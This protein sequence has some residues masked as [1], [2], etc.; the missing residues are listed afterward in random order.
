MTALVHT[1]DGGKPPQMQID[2]MAIHGPALVEM[3]YPILP[4][5]P[6]AKC[7]GRWRQS[8]GWEAYPDWTRHCD[9]LTKPFELGIWEKWPGCGIG[10]AGGKLGGFDI[11]ILDADLS[12]QIE[13]MAHTDLGDSPAIRIGRAPKKLLVYRMERPFQKIAMHPLEFIGHGAQF[14]LY[15]IHP[16][17]QEPY[18]WPIEELSEILPH[19]I[20]IVT[21]AQVRGFMERAIKIVP[22][23]MRQNR[24]PPDRSAERYLV[25]GGD[26]RGT[27]EA[28]AEALEHIPNL[29]W[30]YDDWV[31]IGIA[32][33]GSVGPQGADLF[34]AFSAKSKKDRPDY[35]AK[36]WRGLPEP[37]SKGFGTLWELATSYGWC[38]SNDLIFNQ[39]K[40]DARS[41]GAGHELFATLTT[42]AAPPPHD[43]ETGEIIEAPAKETDPGIDAIIADAGGLLGDLVQWMTSTARYPQ[44]LLSLGAALVMCGSLMGHRYRLLNGPD[45]RSNVM[46][47]GLAGSGSGKDH[48]RRCVVKA[49]S[50]AGLEKFY[51]GRSIASAQGLIATLANFHSG[52]MLLDEAGLFFANMMD[53]RAP[54][55]LRAIGSLLMELSTSASTIFYDAA[56]SADRDPD[57]IRY[58]IPDPCFNLFAT[59]VPEPF[60]QALNSGSA[61]G[62]FLARFLMFETPVNYPDPQFDVPPVEEG[63]ETLSPRM[64]Q[65]VA[66][67]NI[68]ATDLAVSARLGALQPRWDGEKKVRRI[69]LPDVPVVPMSADALAVDRRMAIDEVAQKRANEGKTQATSIIA[70]TTE[71]TRRLAL[72]RAVSRDPLTPVVRAEDMHWGASVVALSMRLMIPAVEHNIADT[73]WEANLK[74]LLGIIRKHGGWMDISTLC[75]RCYFL[76]A[77]ERNEAIIQLLEGGKLESRNEPTATKPRT[78]V[79][80]SG[81]RP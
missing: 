39:A 24:L 10:M 77:K 66:G 79:R 41:A 12:A 74:K 8:A 19:R 60:W 9:R 30:H 40:A 62:G 5:I 22:P 38:P 28:T 27:W 25:R 45:T 31:N 69:N 50:Y 78:F 43:P 52:A 75:N 35:T 70:R 34:A 15:G 49:L 21:E 53:Q 81:G 47:L 55:H 42:P 63:L 51:H 54:A 36:I 65:M 16:D 23:D 48:P 71:H 64:R 44:P 17:T 76:K 26:L 11:D 56:R 14:V 13:A 61:D 68:E 59:T 29:D 1:A 80:V 3:G 32:I 20:P 18:R 46:V 4:I 67:P 37:H 72:I 73:P 57:A 6:G 33:R 58:D 2:W 7:P